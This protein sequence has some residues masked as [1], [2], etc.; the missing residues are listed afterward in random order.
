MRHGGI[1]YTYK[2]TIIR[3]VIRNIIRLSWKGLSRTLLLSYTSL[4]GE[5]KFVSSR[6]MSVADPLFPRD[7]K[8]YVSE[9]TFLQIERLREVKYNKA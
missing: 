3:N 5:I 6:E 8:R 9:I 7:R 2:N 4:S 1:F